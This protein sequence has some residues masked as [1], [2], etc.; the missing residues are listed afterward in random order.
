MIISTGQDN[1]ANAMQK[2]M[3][4]L[5]QYQIVKKQDK[6]EERVRNER[7]Q[8]RKEQAEE[9]ERSLATDRAKQQEIKKQKEQTK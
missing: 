1:L 7:E 8:F 9:Y 4:G 6:Q 2:L 3:I 5:D